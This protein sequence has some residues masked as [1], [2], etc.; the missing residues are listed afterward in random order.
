MIYAAGRSVIFVCPAVP[1][2]HIH[3]QLGRTIGDGDGL[4]VLDAVGRDGGILRIDELGVHR[5]IFRP[6]QR[7]LSRAVHRIGAA[8][9]H[10][11][12][13]HLHNGVGQIR[14]PHHIEHEQIAPRRV[15]LIPRLEGLSGAEIGYLNVA[16]SIG[17]GEGFA[18]T[19]L[20]SQRSVK[21]SVCAVPDLHAIGRNGRDVRRIVVGVGIA[22]LRRCAV[23]QL[24]HRHGGLGREF[25]LHLLAV[26]PV[27]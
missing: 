4:G 25:R 26:L 10:D 16:V 19:Q 7:H 22:A 24:H 20:R 17:N 6:C 8:L 21:G 12:A 13:A 3:V 23:G 14:Y 9:V 2:P 11:F 15:G 18:L 5:A 1:R 27:L